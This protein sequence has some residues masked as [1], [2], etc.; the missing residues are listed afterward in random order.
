LS[1]WIAAVLAAYMFGVCWK[2]KLQFSKLGRLDLATPD[3]GSS[4]LVIIPARNESKHLGACLDSLA[5]NDIV[6]VNDGST[7]NTRD[8]AS[9]KGVTVVNAPPLLPALNPKSSACLA[10]A[11]GATA[12]WLLFVDADARF[13]RGFVDAIVAH[14][15]A[16]RLDVISVLLQPKYG[17]LWNHAILPFWNGIVFGSINVDA[18]HS[19]KLQQLLAYGQCI[20]FRTEAYDFTG[21][22]RIVV[23]N[24]ADDIGIAR[25]VKRH[26]L[27]Y[28]LIR[29]EHLGHYKAG[30]GLWTT[31]KRT[32]YDFLSMNPAGVT[33]QA[34]AAL[35][36]MAL[37]GPVIW[38][39]W[40]EERD[41]AA[42]AFAA[43]P[44]LA[45]LV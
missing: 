10:G 21:G 5:G 42:Y 9:Q 17:A 3:A 22:H 40:Y 20:L 7:D 35:L 36:L 13:E 31:Y 11:K 6:V 34:V 16:N 23:R 12:R 28:E 41:F 25:V 4:T 30:P 45:T 27:R 33:L 26:R 37:W 2:S 44:T 14:A 39:L 24:H 43:I 32:I 1:L 18:V 29:A 38:Y 15:E 8:I 19:V